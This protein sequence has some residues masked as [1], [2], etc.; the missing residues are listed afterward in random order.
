MRPQ[1]REQV[2]IASLVQAVAH[3]HR[4]SHALTI[5]RPEGSTS[6]VGIL[7][8]KRR[9]CLRGIAQIIGDGSKVEKKICGLLES[10]FTSL[11]ATPTAH[12]PHMRCIAYP[13]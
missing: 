11:F 6:E 10:T 9:D 1:Q 5:D 4:I 13:W 3:G 7:G 2:M 8:F 12:R